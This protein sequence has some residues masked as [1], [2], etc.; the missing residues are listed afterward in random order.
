LRLRIRVYQTGRRNVD[1]KTYVS[2]TLR[3]FSV[4]G[5]SR[6]PKCGLSKGSPGRWS[7]RV[8][9]DRRLEKDT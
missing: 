3:R 9:T 4:T 1:G 6:V 7:R 5:S 2:D 8:F